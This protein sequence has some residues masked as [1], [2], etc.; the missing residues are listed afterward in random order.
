MGQVDTC[1]KQKNVKGVPV[2]AADKVIR[3]VAGYN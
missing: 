2:T 1:V 3:E